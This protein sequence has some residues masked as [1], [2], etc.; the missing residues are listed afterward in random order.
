M[1]QQCS[2][3]AHSPQG[4]AFERPDSTAPPLA[5][6]LVWIVQPGAPNHNSS[7]TKDVT[8][9]KVC[10][11]LCFKEEVFDRQNFEATSLR[12]V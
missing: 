2:V 11:V 7:W 1:S 6:H 9:P 10:P 4:V 8:T 5:C 3:D 12:A